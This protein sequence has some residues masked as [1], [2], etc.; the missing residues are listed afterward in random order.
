[1]FCNVSLKYKFSAVNGSCVCIDHYTPVNGVCTEIC[2]DGL[3][4]N[5][6]S[7]ACDDGNLVDL[8]GCSSTCQVENYYRCENGSS[9]SASQCLYT[10][11]PI[12][13][14]LNYI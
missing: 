3:K 11:I 5:S 7:Y 6:S 10:G 14:A 13:I 4:F 8:D 9:T 1:M 2:G 12:E